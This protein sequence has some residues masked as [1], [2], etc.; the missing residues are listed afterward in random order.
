MSLG[1]YHIVY[2]YFLLLLLVIPG[3]IF[4]YIKYHKKSRVRLGIS[5]ILGF[6]KTPKTIKH[7]LFHVP[8]I[9][10]LI[11]IILLVIVIS[12][13]ESRLE[14]NEYSIEGID[15][16]ITSDISGSMLAEDFKPNRLEASKDVATEFIDNRPDDRIGLVVFS[17]ES[18]LQC[19][20]TTDHTRLKDLY[21]KVKSGMITDGTAIGDGLGIAVHHLKKSE[22]I[23]KVII[24]LTDGINNTGSLDP[25]TAAEIAKKFGIRVYTIGVGTKGLAPYP[26]RTNFGIQYQNV[27]VPIDENLLRKIASLTGGEYFRAT[28]KTKLE[29]IYSII[30]KMEKKKIDV[31]R[32]FKGKPE[33]LPFVIAAGIFLLLEFLI[34]YLVL[35]KIP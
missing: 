24:L 34:R 8:F 4:W 3:L 1:P 11:S 27:E 18:F 21:S 22:A 23:S 31:N 35:R 15:I 29:D 16:I 7:Y 32:F 13:P 6:H 26:F 17:A 10:R 20:L 5:N 14:H 12:Q 19:P 33:F 25:M 9:L 30:D 2:P 28:D